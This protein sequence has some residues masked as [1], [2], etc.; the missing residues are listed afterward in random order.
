MGHL[1]TYNIRSDVDGRLKEATKTACNFWNYYVE[2][3][4]NIVLN[5]E[6]RFWM[7]WSAP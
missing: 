7:T 1:I 2:P 6:T 5:V 4:Q 3:K